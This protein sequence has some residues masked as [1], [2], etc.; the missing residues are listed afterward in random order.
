[1]NKPSIANLTGRKQQGF[2]LIEVMVALV[3]VA[4]TLSAL[5][6][7]LSQTVF[8]QGSMQNRVLATWVAQNQMIELQRAQQSGQRLE[9]K[10]TVQMANADW[11]VELKLEPTLIPGIQK[12]S[13]SVTLQGETH[14]S[15]HLVSV[16]GQ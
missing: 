1:M 11:I 2:T 12:A 7:A 15:A 10:Q 16:E 9:K 14:P 8:Q 3:I 13:L 5:S 6:M 4:V